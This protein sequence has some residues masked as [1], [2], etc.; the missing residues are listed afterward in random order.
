MTLDQWLTDHNHSNEW[1]AKQLGTSR[2]NVSNWRRLTSL[3]SLRWAQDVYRITDGDVGLLDWPARQEPRT[4]TIPM[5]GPHGMG[6][7]TVEG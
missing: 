1:L 3:P 6:F 2:A 7:L 4:K 5:P